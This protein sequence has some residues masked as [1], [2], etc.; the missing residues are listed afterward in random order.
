M[1]GRLH[2]VVVAL[3]QLEVAAEAAAEFRSEAAPT[4]SAAAGP[5]MIVQELEDYST[6]VVPL[7]A[8]FFALR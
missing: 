8:D 1:A 4:V 7:V 3:V 2:S 5:A 6:V